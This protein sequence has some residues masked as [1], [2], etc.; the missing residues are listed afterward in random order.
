MSDYRQQTKPRRG[1]YPP[2][3]VQDQVARELLEHGVRAVATASGINR[4]QLISVAAG[5]PVLVGT[6]MRVENW[7]KGAA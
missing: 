5:M 2:K 4:E 1:I 6:V 3:A 7:L